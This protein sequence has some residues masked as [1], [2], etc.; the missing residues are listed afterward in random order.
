LI[1]VV[2]V[3]A[4]GSVTPIDCSRSSPLAIFGRY[5][6]FCCSEPWRSS[7][8]MLYI[9]PWQAPELPPLRLISSMMTDASVR[10]SPDPP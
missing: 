2:S 1:F 5:S 6:R 7:V 3:P 4:V 8:P 9:W 10:L